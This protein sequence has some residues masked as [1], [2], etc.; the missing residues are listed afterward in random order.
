MVITISV[1]PFFSTYCLVYVTGGCQ[2]LPPPASSLVLL[3]GNHNITDADQG[4][5]SQKRDIDNGIG[6]DHTG[7]NYW[8]IRRERSAKPSW[9]PVDV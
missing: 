4:S 3:F 5:D 1:L 9:C 6:D 7:W 8:E 2:L